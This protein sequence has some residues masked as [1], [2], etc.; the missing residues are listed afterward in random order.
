MNN[1]NTRKLA[2]SAIISALS[3]IFLYLSSIV[4]TGQIALFCLSTALF[5][6]VVLECGSGY[7]LLSAVV[8]GM[9]GFIFLPNK[10]L[11]LPYALFFGY[12]PVLKLYIERL[13]HLFLEW[14]IKLSAFIVTM[15]GTFLLMRLMMELSLEHSMPV[16]LIALIGIA[17][18]A[19]Y[20]IALSLF[21]GI[22]REKIAK[23]LKFL[24]KD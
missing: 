18:F 7:A 12:Y 13:G 22:Y 24:R 2:F 21:I 17:V 15:L 5:C 9:L 8:T 11:L 19:V 23:Y 20:D 4:P 16:Y 1:P 10:L 3:L 6:V 14:M